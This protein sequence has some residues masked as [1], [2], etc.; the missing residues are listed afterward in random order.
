[1]AA[2]AQLV[3]VLGV[4]HYRVEFADLVRQEIARLRPAAIAV[5]L[6]STI[7]AAVR[8]AIRR[9]PRLS[10]VV[11]ALASNQTVYLPI[12][13]TDALAEAV[14]SGAERGIPVRFVDLDQDD[15]PAYRDPLP[16]PYAIVRM[17]YARYTA[18][19]GALSRERAPSDVLRERGM[20][21]RAARLAREVDG[22]VLL[23][24]GLAHVNGVTE[25]LR[26]DD[27][28]ETLARTRRA[29]V[30]VFHL[31]PDCLPEVMGEM[32]LFAAVYEHRRAGAHSTPRMEPPPRS[33]APL[34][35]R[36]GPFRVIDGSGE[37]EDG[38]FAAA[39]ARIA[40][41]SGA[42]EP[43]GPGFLDRM[44][45]SASL[46][47]EA[48]TRSESLTGES[49]RAWQRRAFAR[50]A[51]RLAAASRTLVP[52]LF[53][54]VVAGRGCVDE[55]F[56]YELWRLG[57]A[58]P[59][60]SEV[61]DLPT[62]RISGEE[63]LLGMRRIRL[64]PRIPRSGRR[65]RPFPVKRRRGERFPGEFLSGFT[66]EGVCSYPPEDIVI[67]AFG[68]RMKDRGKSILSEERSVTH[69]F[70]ASLE[71]GIDVRETIRH[72]SEGELFVRRT[73]RAPGEVGS[74]VVIFDEEL[75]RER[76]PFML[77]W[78]GEHAEESDMAFYATD[79]REKVVG[80]GICRAEYGGFA[81]SWPP[82]RMADV[83]TDARYESA[84][85]KPERLVLAALDYSMDRFVVLVAPRPPSTRMREWALQ[86]DRQLVHLPIGQFAPT[87]RSR[88]RVLHVLDGHSRRE[89]ARDY[90]W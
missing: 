50:F 12:E 77:T 78:L 21:A 66:G 32:P 19:F 73:G 39:L 65:A 37:S 85:T 59:F 43:V 83:W 28:A 64:R 18:S 51:R 76:Y 82:R 1:M 17:G 68:R 6:P 84:R 15:Y 40:R 3:T 31:H 63:L 58:Y 46:F 2:A 20:A 52:D 62:V 33:T 36:V 9:L 80:P 88:L 25:A 87:T 22:P 34:G 47:E 57:T 16:D 13:P 79:P 4:A 60:Q 38:A 53:D 42:G 49:L 70:V 23:V 69:P 30:S 27:R 67:E 48:A 71:D 29:S 74:V 14:R 45:A 61:A 8:R 55:S 41:E 72:W 10:V 5:E 44:R 7:E 24:C 89:T 81:L 11:Y 86:L 54:L 35:R 75:D 90:I 26:K 56:A